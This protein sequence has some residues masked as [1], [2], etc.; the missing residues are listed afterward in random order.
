MFST[1]FRFETR[2]W[3]RSMMLYVFVF[4]LGLLVFAAASSE[5]VVL[6]SSLDN[7]DRNAP[8]VIQTFYGIMAI[9]TMVMVAAFVIAAALTNAATI[10]V[11]RIAMMP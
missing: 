10:T 6:G 8:F 2:Y 4:V 5:N 11:V 7:T 1:F 9:L 3:L